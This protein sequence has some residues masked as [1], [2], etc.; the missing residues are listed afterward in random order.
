MTLPPLDM[1]MSVKPRNGSR[2]LDRL[3]TLS[4]YDRRTGFVV[5]AYSF[6]FSGSKG[7][8]ESLPVPLQTPVPKVVK[9]GLPGRKVRGKIAP[10]ATSSQNIKDG[11][12][13]YSQ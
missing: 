7:R 9:N 13:D 12:A 11:I 8:E 2:L 6:A 1:L 4:V 10:G 3:Y 5:P